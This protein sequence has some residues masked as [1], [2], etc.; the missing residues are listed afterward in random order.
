MTRPDYDV[1]I[2]G[3]G[4]AGIFAALELTRAG[5]PKIII[6]DKGPALDKRRCPS[7]EKV[8]CMKC[9]TCALLTGWGGAG[10]FSDGKLTLTTDVGGLLADIRGQS[11]AEGLVH[12]QCASQDPA[13]RIRYTQDLQ[14]PLQDAVFAHFA[15][16]DDQRAVRCIFLHPA[17]HIP[18]IDPINPTSRLPELERF[19]RRPDVGLL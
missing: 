18:H 1:I 5:D 12:R 3:A 10:A 17:T 13:A 15:V 2:V 4:P 14:H 6:L 16:D 7:R 9:A 19:E 11:E 8:R